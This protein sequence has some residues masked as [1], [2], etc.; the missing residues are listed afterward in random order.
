MML[1]RVVKIVLVAGVAC[2][3]YFSGNADGS[4]P[5]RT[6]D[7]GGTPPA[8]PTP[9]EQQNGK[10]KMTE[11]WESVSSL[12]GNPDPETAKT[13]FTKYVNLPGLNKKLCGG[14]NPQLGDAV[15]RYLLRLL[16]TDAVKKAQGYQMDSAMRV[17]KASDGTIKVTGRLVKASN[18]PIPV[19][20]IFDTNLMVV[21]VEVAGVPLVV[22]IRS[23][24]RKYFEAHSIR[25]N[26][27]KNPAER[28]T[29]C[30][31]AIE[32]FLRNN[33]V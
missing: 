26:E 16:N 15:C 17:T 9:D 30:T 11:V 22:G 7:S 13:V 10:K 28:A 32:D 6:S 8:L 2:S 24:L 33:P 12:I 29:K 23:I 21:E 3:G 5:R 1:L 14:F 31:E 20:I 19:V 18:D 4:R 27:I 25:I